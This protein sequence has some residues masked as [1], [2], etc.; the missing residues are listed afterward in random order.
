MS[1]LQQERC[2]PLVFG[3]PVEDNEE[4]TVVKLRTPVWC[5]LKALRCLSQLYVG[6]ENGSFAQSFDV[7]LCANR[8]G[9]DMCHSSKYVVESFGRCLSLRKGAFLQ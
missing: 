5:L 2:G 3:D 7:G 6:N 9:D 1:D 8:C 4:E